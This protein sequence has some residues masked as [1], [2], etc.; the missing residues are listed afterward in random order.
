M[1][2]LLMLLYLLIMPLIPIV[3]IGACML[4]IWIP[5]LVFKE[6]RKEFF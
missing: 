2:I 5:Q 6:I 1:N 4:V 3:F